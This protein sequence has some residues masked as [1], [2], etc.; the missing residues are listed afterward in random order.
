MAFSSLIKMRG[1]GPEIMDVETRTFISPKSRVLQ[2][3]KAKEPLR[4]T[5]SLVF[6]L[7]F[8]FIYD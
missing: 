8:T 7:S 5:P 1:Q 6:Y 4:P 3:G 2:E